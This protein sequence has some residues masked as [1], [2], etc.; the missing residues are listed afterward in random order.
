MQYE[1]RIIVPVYEQPLAHSVPHPY[2]GGG[3]Q[4]PYYNP[5]AEQYRAEPYPLAYNQ[6]AGQSPQVN[7]STE[8]EQTENHQPNQHPYNTNQQFQGR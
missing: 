6:M 1:N 2:A 3:Y 4:G 5:Q 8:M 7:P